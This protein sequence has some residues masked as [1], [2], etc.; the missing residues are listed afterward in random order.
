MHEYV[1]GSEGTFGS[2]LTVIGHIQRAGN[3]TASDRILASR[4]GSATVEALLE[5]DGGT[6]VAGCG[7]EHRA[8]PLAEVA[9]KTRP[10]DPGTYKIAE[11]LAGLPE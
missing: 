10:L 3:P 9:G 4:L 11:V 1:N 2:R 7:A 8:R 5:G 6:M